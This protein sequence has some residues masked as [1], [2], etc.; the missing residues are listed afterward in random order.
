MPFVCPSPCPKHL[1]PRW[2]LAVA[3]PFVCLPP[4]LAPRAP[5]PRVGY[6]LLVL[7]AGI[8]RSRCR[9]GYFFLRT[10]R[11]SLFFALPPSF[12]CFPAKTLLFLGL[13]SCH[14]DY[15]DFCRLLHVASPCA[16]LCPEFLFFKI[17]TPVMIC[18]RHPP[19]PPHNFCSDPISK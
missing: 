12:W 9:H 11:E 6:C 1:L 7:E 19:P 14:L 10:L 5:C 18:H 2:R 15:L 3:F 4:I 16:C 17:R 13:Q 8:P